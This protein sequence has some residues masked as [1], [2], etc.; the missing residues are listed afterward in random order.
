MTH[1]AFHGDLP[2]CRYLHHV[3]GAS[4]LVVADEHKAERHRPFWFPMYAAVRRENYLV[5]KWL[6]QEGAVKDLINVGGGYSPLMSLF[7]FGRKSKEANFLVKWFVTQGAIQYW[8]QTTGRALRLRGETN[9]LAD[10]VVVHYLEWSG[11]LIRSTS[12]FR[13]FLLG[14]LRAP[15]YS[16]KAL[17]QLL[18]EKTGDS[19]VA[20]LL[21]Q[22]AVGAGNEGVIWNRLRRRQ[23]NNECLGSHPGIS[24]YI[25][26]FV[27]IVKSKAE[28]DRIKEFHDLFSSAQHDG[29]NYY[30]ESDHTNSDSESSSDQSDDDSG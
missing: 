17:E 16:V 30:N 7:H 19:E 27:G 12:A 4:I 10:A 18:T 22:N 13:S 21:V 20:S 29:T 15:Q 3:R 9:T 2:M 28:L 24:K 8:T 6:F 1:F 26:D 14:T 25:G 11:E 5:A 23:S